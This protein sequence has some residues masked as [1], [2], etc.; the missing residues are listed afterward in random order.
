MKKKHPRP[1]SQGR[2][3]LPPS[4]GPWRWGGEWEATRSLT[5]GGPVGPFGTRACVGASLCLSGPISPSAGVAPDSAQPH[6][7]HC[8]FSCWDSPFS[9]LF[10]YF[11]SSSSS[12][13]FPVSSYDS[14]TFH[15]VLPFCQSQLDFSSHHSIKCPFL[16]LVGP[17]L[18]SPLISYRLTVWSPVGVTSALHPASLLPSTSYGSS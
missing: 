9:L 6:H 8:L 4:Q 2:V 17:S 13:F 10:F 7:Q 14:L 12:F 1:S 5:A 16:L 3:L 15:F 18:L 11:S